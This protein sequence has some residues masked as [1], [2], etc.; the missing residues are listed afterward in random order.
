MGWALNSVK[1]RMTE[2][3]CS[4]GFMGCVVLALGCGVAPVAIGDEAALAAVM[5]DSVPAADLDVQ[6]LL[7]RNG[8]L[9]CHG[10]SYKIVGPAYSSVARKY[11]GDAQALTKLAASIK[12]G[13]VGK[14]GQVAM[15][16]FRSL[17]DA[18]V[19]A[20]ADFVMSQ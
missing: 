17:N 10:T 14:W 12:G 13:S 7:N 3:G 20:L 15:P 2:P 1:G 5:A 11:K 4:I 18:Q 16:G 8:C 9:G 6:A 19:R